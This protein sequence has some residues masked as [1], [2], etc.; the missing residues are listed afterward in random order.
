MESCLYVGQICAGK[1]PFNFL[2]S[3]WKICSKSIEWAVIL[4]L[5]LKSASQY[6]G[7]Q[8][9]DDMCQI[10]FAWAKHNFL[11]HLSII[12]VTGKCLQS[13]W[14]LSSSWTLSIK[15]WHSPL[16]SK[17]PQTHFL[18]WIKNTILLYSCSGIFFLSSD[19]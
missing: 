5:M 7:H 16:Q 11:I 2:P 4:A 14:W 17:R 6:T 9:K 15:C 19:C 13:G 1:C 10:N 18:L 8:H 3:P 12:K